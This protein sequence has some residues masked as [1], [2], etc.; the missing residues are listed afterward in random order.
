MDANGFCNYGYVEKFGRID[1]ERARKEGGAE[2]EKRS[3][4][5]SG[6]GTGEKWQA[7]WMKVRALPTSEAD[8]GRGKS[9]GEG[10]GGRRVT[11]AGRR[12]PEDEPRGGRSI[13]V[14]ACEEVKKGVEER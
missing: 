11:T 7:E 1:K 13:R 10:I 12:R 14:G 9:G 6:G 5:T 2:G 8:G 4:E 3:K